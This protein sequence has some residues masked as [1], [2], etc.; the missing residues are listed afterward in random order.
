[1]GVALQE[2]AGGDAG[3]RTVALDRLLVPG[4]RLLAGD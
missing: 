4:G 1:M 2:A 3:R